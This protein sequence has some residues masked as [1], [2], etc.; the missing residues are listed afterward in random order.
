MAFID[1]FWWVPRPLEGLGRT[2]FPDPALTK[3]RSPE[4]WPEKPDD[5]SVTM[6]PIASDWLTGA[7]DDERKEARAITGAHTLNGSIRN[8]NLAFGDGHVETR[9]Y[10]KVQWQAMSARGDFAYFY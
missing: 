3:S 2:K 8:D 1:M 5:P 7:W 6:K 10:S 9:P 4:P